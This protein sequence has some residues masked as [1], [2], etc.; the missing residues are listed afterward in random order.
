MTQGDPDKEH[1]TIAL[2]AVIPQKVG[3]TI[4]AGENTRSGNDLKD[5]VQQLGKAGIGYP[6]TLS[7]SLIFELT[8]DEEKIRSRP[9]QRKRQA[10]A[11]RP[12]NSKA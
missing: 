6:T 10:E 11:V 7:L 4:R 3:W 12:C 1:T 9:N 5:L 2:T 8:G